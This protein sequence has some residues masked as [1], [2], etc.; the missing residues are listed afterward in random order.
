MKGAT[1]I[2]W[3]FYVSNLHHANSLSWL[4]KKGYEKKLTIN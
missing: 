3:E 4:K 1:H 2:A